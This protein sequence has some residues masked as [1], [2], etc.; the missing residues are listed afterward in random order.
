VTNIKNG[1][2]SSTILHTIPQGIQKR[3][4]ENIG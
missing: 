2:H 3:F 1:K 4:S